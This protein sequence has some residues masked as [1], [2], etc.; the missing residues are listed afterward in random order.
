VQQVMIK[1]YYALPWIFGLNTGG[2]YPL[3]PATLADLENANRTAIDPEVAR[4]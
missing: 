1:N 3:R 2:P 4:K